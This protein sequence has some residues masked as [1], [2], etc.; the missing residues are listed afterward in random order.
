[1]VAAVHVFVT[2]WAA[3]GRN[4]AMLSKDVGV[5]APENQRIERINKKTRWQ[6]F[7]GP[8]HA[9]DLSRAQDLTR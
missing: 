7:M 6:I 1:P 8:L 4:S 3:H 9:D 2:A 5:S